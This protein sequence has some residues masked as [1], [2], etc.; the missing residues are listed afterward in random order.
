MKRGLDIKFPNNRHRLRNRPEVDATN[1]LAKEFVNPGAPPPEKVNTGGDAAV[2][3]SD[4]QPRGGGVSVGSGSGPRG[5]GSQGLVT[6]AP[7][8]K[9]T[10][11]SKSKATPKPAVRARKGKAKKT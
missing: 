6:P 1:I 9:A 7:K 4:G 2:F 8:S 11:V 3:G 5:G 10:A